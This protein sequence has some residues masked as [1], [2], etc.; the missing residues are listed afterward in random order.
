[1][2]FLC[3]PSR[4]L[5][6]ST[7]KKRTPPPLFQHF[8]SFLLITSWQVARAQV[9][10]RPRHQQIGPTPASQSREGGLR[11]LY[12]G[13]GR[14]EGGIGTISGRRGCTNAA[15]D[16]VD[17][18][19]LKS[20]EKKCRPREPAETLARIA[21]KRS[22]EELESPC[23]FGCTARRGLNLRLETPNKTTR[24][25]ST[26]TETHPKSRRPFLSSGCG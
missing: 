12:A 17:T 23:M 5:Q 7:T 18:F 4:C 16:F 22:R 20:L 2:F 1:M 11:F 13:A 10:V 26:L 9:D 19:P 14:E 21:A 8:S 6:N 15:S 3:Y 24:I 25:S